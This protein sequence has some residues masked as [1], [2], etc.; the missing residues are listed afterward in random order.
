VLKITETPCPDI[1]FLTTRSRPRTIRVEQLNVAWDFRLQ[2]KF[3]KR[4]DN[5]FCLVVEILA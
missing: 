2:G 4:G 3:L 5:M 1:Q